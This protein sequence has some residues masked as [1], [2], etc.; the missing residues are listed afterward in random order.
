MCI[1]NLAC[2]CKYE[3]ILFF[4]IFPKHAKNIN[5]DSWKHGLKH[6]TA[7]TPTSTAITYA[8]NQYV[9]R[10]W[11]ENNGKFFS[12]SMS[13]RTKDRIAYSCNDFRLTFFRFLPIQFFCIRSSYIF[14]NISLYLSLKKMISNNDSKCWFIFNFIFHFGHFIVSKWT[15]RTKM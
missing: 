3:S 9:Y 5:S 14:G 4:V 11:R 12:H 6:N 7:T 13:P 8:I 2:K 1:V 10:F 15:S